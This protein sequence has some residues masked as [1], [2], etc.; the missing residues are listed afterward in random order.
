MS[1]AAE[2]LTYIDLINRLTDLERLAILPAPGEKCA[3]WSSYDRGSRYD[4]ANDKYINW[5]GNTDDYGKIR[6]EGDITVLA[7]MQGPGVIWRAWSAQARKG[8]VKIYLDGKAQP[9]VDLPFGDYFNAANPPFNYKS[10]SYQL[11]SRQNR[12]GGRNLYVPIP[13]QKSC[14]ITGEGD[15]GEFF[16]FTYTTYPKTTRLPTFKRNLSPAELE[17]LER[18]NEILA[19]CG[20]DP[21]GV[22]PGQVTEQRSVT[23]APGKTAA[24]VRLKGTRAITAINVKMDLPTSGK[25]YNLLRELALSIYWDGESA[26]S[27]W[28]PLGD[29]FGTAPSFNKY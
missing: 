11:L 21:A 13:Y 26:P 16:H 25:D 15:W 18:A 8:P 7:E 29:F 10:L 19:N 23:I 2:E 20:A 14:R 1:S 3:Q 24:I 28:S 27:I 17:A 22:R 4:E 9:V 5:D 6:V 12:G